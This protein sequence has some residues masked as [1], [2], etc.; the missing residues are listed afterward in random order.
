MT[1]GSYCCGECS[2]E[3]GHACIPVMCVLISRCQ[4]HVRLCTCCMAVAAEQ[5]VWS[6]LGN[7]GAVARCKTPAGSQSRNSNFPARIQCFCHHSASYQMQFLVEQHQAA[8]GY[9][10]S[11]YHASRCQPL[12]WLSTTYDMTQ[13]A[14]RLGVVAVGSRRGVRGCC[15]D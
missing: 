5:S 7:L 10:V 6:R 14:S 8:S 13:N 11:C 9:R 15:P 1:R 4:A 3:V 2:L 12:S